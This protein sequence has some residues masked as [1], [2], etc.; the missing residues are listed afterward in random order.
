MKRLPKRK[1]E[2]NH[3]FR[4]VTVDKGYGDYLK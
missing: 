2:D 1:D 4:V 3:I